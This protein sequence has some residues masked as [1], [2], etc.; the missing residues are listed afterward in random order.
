VTFRLLIVLVAAL[1]AT[2]AAPAAAGAAVD[3]A[4]TADGGFA[5]RADAGALSGAP[6]AVAVSG[7]RIYQLGETA[8]A[9]GTLDIGI[10]ARHADGTLDTGF[11]GDG[12]LTLS[13]A[14]GARN[15][16]AADLVVLPDGGLRIAG[17]TD[18]ATSDDVLLAGLR[19]DGSRSPPTAGSRS[20]ATRARATPS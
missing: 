10:V 14:A 18:E 3:P 15:D 17:S 9:G 2:A 20:P 4:L 16:R 12:R 11:D 7:D 5:T 13:V 8:G 6:H 1:A 19:P